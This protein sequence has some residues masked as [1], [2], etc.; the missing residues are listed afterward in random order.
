V[1]FDA[2]CHLWR[3]W[4]FEPIE[5]M[6]DYP[7]AAGVTAVPDP[8]TR[9][10]VE[11]LIFEM[12]MN[13]VAQAA[14][15]CVLIQKNE[16]NNE[17]VADCVRRYPSR[18]VQFADIDSSRSSTYH[19]PG[20]AA[21]LAMAAERFGLR[22]LTHYIKRGDD[23]SWYGSPDG[24]ALFAQAADLGLVASISCPDPARLQ[25]VMRD[26][27]AR[28]PAM[29]FILHHLGLVSATEEPPYAGI[30]AVLES[31]RAPNIYIKLSGPYYVSH[32]PWDYPY[33]DCLW[34]VRA[35][36]EHYGPD[37]LCWGSDSP[38][39]RDA[40]NYRQAV[41]FVRTH[42]PFIPPDHQQRVLGGN[43]HRLLTRQ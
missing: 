43:L 31:A 20:G 13:D 10:A 26:L 16:D 6:V 39:V 1:L 22:G 32:T 24:L 37:R 25:P 8:L 42:C 27:A 19:T 14:V 23:G 5:R 35:L 15:I 3:V 33:S 4:P 28:F 17:Y 38:V 21:R 29:P 9:S 7:N 18:L 30:K 41:E 40:M 2:H 11:Q 12:D 36:Y 34:I